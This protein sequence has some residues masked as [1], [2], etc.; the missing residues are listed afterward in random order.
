MTHY[1]IT[2]RKINGNGTEL[3]SIPGYIFSFGG[4]RYGVSNKGFN[5]N[6]ELVKLYG[7]TVT[8]LTTGFVCYGR[9][10]RTRQEAINAFVKAIK[11][12]VTGYK[13]SIQAAIDKYLEQGNTDANAGLIPKNEI[14][15]AR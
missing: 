14:L 13:A 9:R 11:D 10:E 12:D 3:K 5:E 8:E 15:I 4:G 6:G 2:C 1:N 7:W